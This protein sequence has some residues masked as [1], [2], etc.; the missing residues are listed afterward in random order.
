M[1]DLCKVKVN[2]KKK[3]ALVA[4]DGKKDELF[5]WVSQNLEGLKKHDLLGTGTTASII[6]EKFDLDITPYLSGPLGG[7]QKIGS[8]IAENE[9]DIL[10]FFW[11]PL[12]AQ[13]HDP[14]VKALLRIAV[15][16]DVPVAMSPT[17]ANYLFASQMINTS[18]DKYI[19]DN[20]KNLKARVDQFD[21]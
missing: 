13:P 16:Y 4:H 17:S 8:L 15:L 18:Y 12:E 20:G 7:D 1:E 19:I 11:D 3:I 10:I 21:D 2:G 9:V 14:D 6:Q 5:Y